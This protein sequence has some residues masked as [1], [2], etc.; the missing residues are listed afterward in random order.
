MYVR[1]KKH[2]WNTSETRAVSESETLSSLSRCF[3][4]W[5]QM[6]FLRNYLFQSTQHY[7]LCLFINTSYLEFWKRLFY[8]CPLSKIVQPP[9]TRLTPLTVYNKF[10]LFILKII[11]VLG[12]FRHCVCHLFIC[13]P[14][15][16]L[17]YLVWWQ[18]AWW[19]RRWRLA[20]LS[21]GTGTSFCGLRSQ[22]RSRTTLPSSAAPWVTRNK[23][24]HRPFNNPTSIRSR[25]SQQRKE[26]GGR[27]QAIAG[28]R[29]CLGSLLFKET[30]R[31]YLWMSVCISMFAT[32]CHL[33]ILFLPS[34]W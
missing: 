26:D 18:G 9:Q 2:V 24:H 12:H 11:P 16:T 25:K 33:L 1:L 23:G 13:V 3:K 8:T 30:T 10:Y 15:W 29:F 34:L 28:F 14:V 20:R 6:L 19:R 22:R 4:Y 31:L 5:W 27:D 21:E 32:L 7:Y 17:L